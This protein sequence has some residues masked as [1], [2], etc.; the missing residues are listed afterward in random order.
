MKVLS[1][2][3]ILPTVVSVGL[4]L[5][6]SLCVMYGFVDTYN[7]HRKSHLLLSN[8]FADIVESAVVSELKRESPPD[9][10]K[11]RKMLG[12]FVRVS[13]VRVV[14]L[15]MGT[16][17]II[18]SRGD[19][20]GA[21]LERCLGSNECN[22]YKIERVII[23]NGGDKFFLSTVFDFESFSGEY[24]VSL[25]FL[26]TLFWLLCV[27]VLL[28]YLLWSGIVKMRELNNRLDSERKR[29]VYVDE[30]SL[31]AAG[32]AHETKN[33]LGIIRGLAQSIAGDMDNSE[34]T[35]NMAR[36]IMEET[37]VTTAR[38]GDFLSYAKFRSPELIEIDA[39]EYIV[40]LTELI[41][42]DMS[43]AGVCLNV[44]IASVKILADK[45]MLSQILVNLLTNSL[46]YC[47]S[48]GEIK[49]ILKE[50]RGDTVELSVNDNGFGIPEEVLPNIF[51][52]YFTNSSSGYGIG[53]AIVKR[54]VEQ[55]GWLIRVKS[56]L[57]KGTT[58]TIYNIKLVKARVETES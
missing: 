3:L 53:L 23:I 8:S 16:E 51:K 14:G 5:F 21:D 41:R 55:S 13:S 52:P 27:I 38:L 45:D 10:K 26:S 54:I 39:N 35:R 20:K 15:K 58:V 32:L 11:I 46:K 25:N 36:D 18:V 22:Y 9:L 37:D 6:F 57:G 28:F 33:P 17:S 12:L 34:K 56:K 47:D 48:G 42:D 29:S 40:R 4:F 7:M 19:L 43:N 31:A 50:R 49:V 24:E 1:R 2:K 44:D 30:L